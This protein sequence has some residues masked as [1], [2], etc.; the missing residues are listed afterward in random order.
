MAEDPDKDRDAE[1]EQRALQKWSVA[2]DPNPERT[3][4]QRFNHIFQ[5]MSLMSGK[6]ASSLQVHVAEPNSRGAQYC[7]LMAAGRIH[8]NAKILSLR[9]RRPLSHSTCVAWQ[10]ELGVC[11]FGA[12]G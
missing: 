9:G 12:F 1:F 3:I 5:L 6:A 2:N 8:P 10:Q 11:S 4:S 7:W